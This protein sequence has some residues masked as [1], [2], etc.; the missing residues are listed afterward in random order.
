MTV[1][2]SRKGTYAGEAT[3]QRM[4]DSMFITAEYTAENNRF[5][6]KIKLSKFLSQPDHVRRQN[7]P[8]NRDKTEFGLNRKKFARIRYFGKFLGG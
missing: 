6:G 7:K 4:T 5:Y 2:K 1:L 8:K 3:M